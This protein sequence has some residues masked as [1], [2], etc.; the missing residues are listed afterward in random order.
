V[1][2]AAKLAMK[3]HT[4]NEDVSS[5]E[6]RTPDWALVLPTSIVMGFTFGFCLEK[7]RVFEPMVIRGQFVFERWIMLKMF[8]AAMATSCISFALCCHFAPDQFTVVRKKMTGCCDGS[9]AVVPLLRGAIGAC[10][11]GVGMAIS[12]ACPGMVLSQLGAG[13]ETSYSTLLGCLA[14]AL[15][16]GLMEPSLEPTI[17]KR[18]KSMVP[19]VD[20]LLK[21]DYR[22]LVTAL[23][24]GMWLVV[25]ILE[26]AIDWK[27]DLTFPNP[28]GCAWVWDCV[29][30]P[31]SVAGAIVGLLQIP[32]V[33]V[34]SEFLGGSRGYCTLMA[35]PIAA[36][37]E[38]Q[39][40]FSYLEGTRAG[41]ANYWQVV[42][43]VTAVVGSVV[44]AIGSD[45]FA[46][47]TGV[48]EGAGASCSRLHQ[49]CDMLHTIHSV[50]IISSL[51]PHRIPHR[52]LL[53]SPTSRRS[54]L[55]CCCSGFVGGFL[56]LFGSRM[57]AGCTS[58]HGFSGMG[59]LACLR[60]AG[61]G[62]A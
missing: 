18:G 46:K 39:A 6:T 55:V 54:Y 22:L 44:S 2:E 5:P 36:N 43:L 45:T 60:C 20:Q 15:V 27:S 41:L 11:L 61:Q 31:P 49:S 53:S 26:V 59:L 40:K 38:L 56:M 35:Q 33:L 16:F 48:S 21:A 50:L 57:G 28:M 14:G 29:A 10:L 51:I 25:I 8:L 62:S 1:G 17:L 12:G 47:V 7:S 23:G 52:S 32:A 19:Y 13:V 34:C 9:C 24:V 58:G 42:Y 4:T 37:K 3:V 30:W